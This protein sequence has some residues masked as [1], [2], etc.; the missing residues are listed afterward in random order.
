MAGD[1]IKTG[2]NVDC[3]TDDPA[4][5]ISQ[6]EHVGIAGGKLIRLP[7]VND[8]AAMSKWTFGEYDQWLENRL[9]ILDQC[10]DTLRKFNQVVII[11][12]HHTV[13]G[14]KGSKWQVFY[15]NECHQHHLSTLQNVARRYKDNDRIYGIEPF[16]EPKPQ[17]ASQLRKFY[18]ELIPWIRNENFQNWIVIDH[19]GDDC[20]KMKGATP[21]PDKKLLYS[22][23]FYKPA[24]VL[25]ANGK[26]ANLNKDKL[27][28]YL[29]YPI[30]FA[31][32]YG[33]PMIVG[34]FGCVRTSGKGTNQF[35]FIQ[36][37]KEL[38]NEF[39]WSWCLHMESYNPGN[40]FKISEEQ[41]NT[42]WA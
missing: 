7:L 23:H 28:G 20:D 26:V 40:A 42:L 37:S 17:S 10:M 38:F 15:N 16:N 27:R 8:P 30:Q 36:N 6:L 11:D 18:I 32:K 33:V 39:K 41:F 19:V 25:Q 14:K 29:K 13:G 31:I 1:E 9:W 34:E 2:A 3:L 22:I 21:L 5:L 12:F 35:P 4:V 24:E